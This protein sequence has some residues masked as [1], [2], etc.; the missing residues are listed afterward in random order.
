M[1]PWRLMAG[2]KQLALQWY[3]ETGLNQNNQRCL[4]M[5]ASNRAEL[6]DQLEHALLA[7]RDNPE[8]MLGGNGM[9]GTVLSTSF[10]IDFSM[11]RHRL[12]SKAKLRLSSPVP[13]IILPVWD[14]TSQL[15]GPLSTVIRMA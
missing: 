14:V 11:P 8:K 9:N 10:A 4:A 12:Q 1:S 3:R 15:V 13:A 2:S 7:L 5:V 6:L